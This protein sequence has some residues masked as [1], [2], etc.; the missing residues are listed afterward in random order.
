MRK[1]SLLV[2]FLAVNLALPV[3]AQYRGA[4]P[5][6]KTNPR[7]VAVLQVLPTGKARLLP[8]SIFLNGQFYDARYYM[9]KPVPLALYDD[10][11]YEALT[12]GLPSGQF[13]VHTARIQPNIIWGEGDWRLG[14]ASKPS[15]G[16]PAPIVDKGP[17]GT[18]VFPGTVKETKEERRQD[19]RDEKA[20]KKN[21]P[22]P[23]PPSTTPPPTNPPK[24]D[25]DPDRPTLKKT[26][27]G[28]Q[29]TLKPADVTPKM[30]ADNDS[31]RPVLTRANKGEQE[32]PEPIMA[33]KSGIAGAKYIVAVSDPDPMENRPYQY[34]WTDAEKA[35]Y[36]QQLSKIAMDSIKKYVSSGPNK[37]PLPAD[38]KFS[39]VQVRAF[40]LDYSNSPYLVFTGEIEPVIPPPTAK[41]T[42]PAPEQAAI[43][44]ASLVVRVNS[45]GDLTRLL[46]KVTDSRHLDAASRYDLIDAVDADGDNRAEL[47][48]KRTNDAGSTYVLFRVTPFELTQV[49]EGGAAL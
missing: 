41:V 26:E 40:D 10:T 32:K 21:K 8:V 17:S 33:P 49:F 22:E 25:D 37:P 1:S 18:V 47:L 4:A 3:L 45:T 27:A 16:K 46:N 6:K 20:H 12:D 28:P 43:I 2:F 23:R 44:Y 7:A 39:N 24:D 48:F 42:T 38:A 36:T 29:V 34:N 11:V 19:K 13:T 30:P 31:D 15:H 9:A 14:A 5:Q 35:K